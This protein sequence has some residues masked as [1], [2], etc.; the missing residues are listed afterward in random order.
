LSGLNE[1][2][3]QRHG[4]TTPENHITGFKEEIT[5]AEAASKDTFFGWFNN[6]DDADAAF[7]EGVWDFDAHIGQPLKDIYGPLDNLKALEIGYG[8]GRLIA[9]AAERFNSVIGVDIHHHRERVE[10]ELKQRGI[11]NFQLLESDGKT[12]PLEDGSVDIVYSFVVLQHVQFID[13]FN[14]YLAETARVLKPGGHGVLYYGR[15]HR[16][17]VNT[18][19]KLRYMLD[20]WIEPLALR[21]RYRELDAAI[22][23]TN[24]RVHP[25][26][27]AAQARRLGLRVCAT[28]PSKRNTPS[29]PWR[30]GRQHGVVLSKP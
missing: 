15:F 17:S 21:G 26:Y 29:G 16:F 9:A 7:A 14:Q 25:G 2:H 30:Y 3:L 20:R 6:S 12:L 11:E 13:I 24:L 10:T 28:L 5:R 19:S 22:N 4:L 1:T 18:T 23:S 8:G 27:V